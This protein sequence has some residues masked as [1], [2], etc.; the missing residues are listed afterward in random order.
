M[1]HLSQIST[2]SLNIFQAMMTV[3]RSD[4]IDTARSP[5]IVPAA[6]SPEPSPRNPVRK[7][8][9]SN[10]VERSETPFRFRNSSYGMEPR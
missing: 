9:K 8:P 5:R 4:I 1:S 10:V 6:P 7:V 2:I 3:S